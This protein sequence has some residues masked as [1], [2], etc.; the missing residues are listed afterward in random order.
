MPKTTIIGSGLSGM[1]GS[2]FT[3]MFV[4]DF[5][6]INLDL[7][8]NIDITNPD[9]IDQV[10]S[11]Y[12]STSVIHL[13]AFTDVSKAY[14]ET[15]KKQG[16]VYQINVLGTQN[17]ANACKKY[18]HYLIH[19]STDFVFDGKNPPD[20][21]YTEEDQPYPIEWYGQTKL[22]A[23]QK[24]IDSGCQHAIARLAFPF[25]AH[26]LTKPDLVRNILEKLK[27][28]SLHP[29][30]TDQIITPTFIDDIC[31]VLKVFIDKKPSG[32]Y[33]VVGSTSL[34]PY[35]LAVKIAQIFN[36]KAKIK[37]GSF[38]EYLKTD[39]RPRNQY[40]KVSNAKLKKDLGITMKTIDEALKTFKSQLL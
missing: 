37:P 12:P 33:H 17:I 27:T 3:E 2:R 19:I 26:F 14:A 8:N 20:N 4:S 22:W 40:S 30:F 5:D 38:K 7:T 9:Q 23:E 39:P 6:F 34:A 10:L 29:M 32:I 36:L 21:G 11:Q 13:A 18:H 16:K 28:N 24:V 1:V 35:D 25:R 15:G 31:Q